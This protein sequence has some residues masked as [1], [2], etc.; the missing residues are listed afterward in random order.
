ME[1]VPRGEQMKVTQGGEG[2][3]GEGHMRKN[4]KPGA[5]RSPQPKP[6]KAKTWNRRVQVDEE[7]LSPASTGESSERREVM[8]AGK[9]DYLNRVPSKFQK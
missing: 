3:K 6:L 5:I 2:P 7:T 9:N 1:E 4:F 8:P